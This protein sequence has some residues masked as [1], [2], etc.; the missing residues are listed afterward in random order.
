MKKKKSPGEFLVEIS[1]EKMWHDMMRLITMMPFPRGIDVDTADD[2]KKQVHLYE[3]IGIQNSS[4]VHEAHEGIR[5][6]ADM[7]EILCVL[8]F[9]L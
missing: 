7:M 2:H 8:H 4:Y 9:K 6:R 5:T 1:S 3:I